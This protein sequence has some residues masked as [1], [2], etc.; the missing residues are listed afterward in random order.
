M[1]AHV[2]PLHRRAVTVFLLVGLPVL[3]LGVL[4]VLALGQSRLRDLNGQHLGQVASQTAAAVDTYMY[5]RL[6]DASMLGRVPMLRDAVV[7]S[8]ARPY[9][10]EAA[11]RR[12]AEA[13]SGSSPRQAALESPAS[14]FLADLATSDPIY[15][16]LLLTDRHG[17]LVAASSPAAGYL[18]WD[19]DW[20]RASYADGRQGRAT[21][22][23]V[24]RDPETGR[25]VMTMVVPVTSPSSELA[26]ILRV[27]ADSREML[28]MVGGVQLGSTGQAMLV[29][30]DGSIVF[31]RR[32][33]EPSTR[34]FAPDSLHNQVQQLASGEALE[35]GY[36][37]ASTGGRTMLVGLAPSQ[38]ARSFPNITWHVAVMQSEDEL[39]SPLQGL[40]WYL[41][42]TFA[43]TAIAI[44]AFALW[45]SMQLAKPVMD[46]DIH[47]VE[48]PP[49]MHV[50]ETDDPI[51]IAK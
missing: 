22:T 18:Q 24:S 47:L 1:T 51:V 38:L 2:P 39:A 17:R 16:E 45:F 28:A 15:L 40:G 8:S 26:G 27:V 33:G 21:L 50:G 25:H 20:W 19:Q 35:G 41:L 34:F 7:E 12:A 37:A 32:F 3:A 43:I 30:P 10:G 29:R 5:R 42:L 44:L 31:S 36:F 9:G 49:V 13:T 23:D 4:V 46:T 48:H 11:E 6:I 14:R